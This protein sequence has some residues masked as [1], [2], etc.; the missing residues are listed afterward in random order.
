MVFQHAL[1]VS[2]PTS[3]GEVEGS[4]LEVVSRPHLGGKIEGS[5]LGVSRPTPGGSTGSTPGG[6]P[7]MH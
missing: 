2:R 4:S 6:Y 7:R 3:R 5:D 1:Q